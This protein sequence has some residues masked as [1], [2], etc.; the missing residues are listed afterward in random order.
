MREYDVIIAGAGIIGSAIAYQLSRFDLRVLI[1]ERH[2]YAASVTTTGNSA[3]IHCGFDAKPEESK[4]RFNVEGRL[5][6]ERWFQ[7]LDIP[8]LKS[9]SL[10]VALDDEEADVCR[11]LVERGY[12]NGLGTDELYYADAAG[13]A[14]FERESQTD[15]GLAKN[16]RGALICKSSW[17]IDPVIATRTLLNASAQNGVEYLSD[18]EVVAIESKDEG[19]LVITQDGRYWTR[20]FINAAGAGAGKI[21]ETIGDNSIQI[22]SRRGQYIVVQGKEMDAKRA[23]VIF[24]VPSKLGKGVLVA[25][26]TDGTFIIGPTAQEGID[27]ADANLIDLSIADQLTHYAQ[28]LCPKI[29]A[30][31]AIGY[32]AGTRA[33]N[34]DGGDF[35]IRHSTVDP[36]IIHVAGIQSPGLSA[37]PAIARHVCEKLLGLPLHERANFRPDYK[38]IW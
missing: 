28:L 34:V 30:S 25:P 14:Q 36:N 23:P 7:H 8:R 17:I 21:A 5:L 13:L 3:I 11:G 35:I 2:P 16:V 15:F 27:F 26:R 10:V 32:Y 31:R 12:V 4:A 33:I 20:R 29:N 37:A 19:I 24:G 6:W 22:K 1:I 9:P 38:H 18:T